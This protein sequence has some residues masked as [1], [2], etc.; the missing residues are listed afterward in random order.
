MKKENFKKAEQYAARIVD[1]LTEMFNDD[2]CSNHIPLLELS[3][4]DNLKCLIHALT[5][6]SAMMFNEITGE[7]KNWLEFNHIANSLCVEFMV[8]D[9]EQR[10]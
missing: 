9:D 2:S 7:E 8:K 5:C 3:K 1:Q 4:G 6:A 10:K